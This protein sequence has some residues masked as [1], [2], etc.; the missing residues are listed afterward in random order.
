[1]PSAP[2]RKVL[3]TEKDAST[4][5]MRSRVAEQYVAGARVGLAVGLLVGSALVLSVV[6]GAGSDPVRVCVGT[7]DGSGVNETRSRSEVVA[8]DVVGSEVVCE[9]VEL[10]LTSSPEPTVSSLSSMLSSSVGAEVGP[11]VIGAGVGKE[12][13]LE[14]VR[15]GA[16]VGVGVGSDEDGNGVGGKMLGARVG[17]EVG[18]E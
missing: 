7:A 16:R 4:R 1:M 6:V 12:I 14:V 9:G 2:P 17:D 3:S 11:E 13:G 10:E 8:S 18:S 5:N 15:A